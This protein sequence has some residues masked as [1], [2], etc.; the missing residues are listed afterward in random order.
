MKINPDE[1][2]NNL[3]KLTY[4]S[5]PTYIKLMELYCTEAGNVPND[6]ILLWTGDIASVFLAH[7]MACAINIDLSKEEA[8]KIYELQFK[9]SEPLFL[10]WIEKLKK[11]MKGLIIT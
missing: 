4:P 1:K 11:E 6:E 2:N 7:I 5:Y 9:K 8:L 10:E 3:K